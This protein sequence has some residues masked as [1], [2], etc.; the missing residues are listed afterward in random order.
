MTRLHVSYLPANQRWALVFGDALLSVGGTVLWETREALVTELRY[1]GLAVAADGAVGV[2]DG[3]DSPEGTLLYNQLGVG[4]YSRK[5][6][7]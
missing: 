1:N 6:T 7:R 3:P 4:T 2:L 5:E